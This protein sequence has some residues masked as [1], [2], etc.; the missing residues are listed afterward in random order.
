M[1]TVNSDGREGW[2]VVRVEGPSADSALLE[3]KAQTCGWVRGS[4]L[5]P[6]GRGTSC[7]CAV[8][9]LV[10]L[11]AGVGVWPRRGRGSPNVGH[12]VGGLGLGAYGHWSWC[13]VWTRGLDICAG[14]EW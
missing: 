11:Q 5:R 14:S 7:A 3:C 4:S 9:G 12:G 6:E 1:E 10:W 2:S 8:G 13:V